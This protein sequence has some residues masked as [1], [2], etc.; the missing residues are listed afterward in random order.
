MRSCG[1][2]HFILIHTKNNYN[3]NNRQASIVA[4]KSRYIR[5]HTL[6]NTFKK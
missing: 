5:K 2:A 3:S 1:E 6:C 4:G